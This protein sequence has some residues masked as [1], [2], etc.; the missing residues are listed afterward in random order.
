MTRHPLLRAVVCGAL[1]SCSISS[2]APAQPAPPPREVVDDEGLAVF[3]ERQVD[4]AFVLADLDAGTTVVVG[5][6]NADLRVTPASTFKIPNALIAL[7]TGVASGPDFAL[8]WDGVARTMPDWNRDHTL[9]SA[10]RFSVVWYFREIARR[11]GAARMQ[12]YVDALAY[13]NRDLSGGI[14]RFWLESSLRISPREQAAFAGRLATGALPLRPA[15]MAAVR[16]MLVVERDGGSVLSGKTGSA[17]QDGWTIGW[18]VGTFTR[19]TGNP[20]IPGRSS[21]TRRFAYATLLLAPA[22]QM[23]RLR[24]LRLEITKALLRRRGV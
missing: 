8:R 20:Q 15:T 11:I 6:P 18:L 17:E 10:I 1:L 19:G 4:G 9:A 14:D 7:E 22:G 13:G 5:S 12:R 2:P 23:E 24:P 21:A 3:R 16:E